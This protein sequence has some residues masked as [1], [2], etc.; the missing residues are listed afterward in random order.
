MV[1]EVQADSVE[2]ASLRERQVDHHPARY[3]TWKSS[4]FSLN[5]TNA[6][7]NLGSN[8]RVQPI[9]LPPEGLGLLEDKLNQDVS[10]SLHSGYDV[11]EV[12]RARD[13]ANAM[14]LVGVGGDRRPARAR[15]R[16]SVIGRSVRSAVRS[17]ARP[18]GPLGSA[19]FVKEIRSMAH[20]AK[21]AREER[22]MNPLFLC[23]GLLRWSYKPGVFAE[24]PLIL[25]PVNIAVSAGTTRVHSLARLLA[26]DNSQCCPHRVAAARAR[27]LDP[28]TSPNRWQTGPASTSMACLPRYARRLLSGACR[29]DVSGEARIATLDLSAFRMWQDLN[30]NADHFFE[31]P[32]VKHLVDTPTE[33][34]EDPAIEAAGDAASDEAFEDE[35]EKLETP[36]PADSTQKRAVLWARQGRT[37]VLQGPPGT[38]KSQT[39]TNMVA[40]CLLAGLRVLFVA[41][42]GTALAVVQRRLDAIGLGPFTLNLHHEGSNAAEVRAQLK[43]VTH[44]AASTPTTWRWRAPAG[45]SETRASS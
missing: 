20:S 4:L 40:E 35:L 16:S 38:G 45:G 25:V 5:A 33:T 22:G 17:C 32:L 31:R 15:L 2:A 10:F 9:V 36:I 3:R 43:R 24:A 13:I 34:F 7:L 11:P 18:V 8:A 37:F 21:T 26:A 12:W 1:T 41:E 30:L 39:I 44:G 27:T 23:I 29:L 6:L 28:R 14:Q 42:K 19:T